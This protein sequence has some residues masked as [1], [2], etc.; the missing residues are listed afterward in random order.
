MIGKWGGV[1]IG[2][3][4]VLATALAAP[5]TA[6]AIDQSSIV[7][8]GTR[9]AKLR[10]ETHEFV[11]GLGAFSG[12]RQTARWVNDVC[13][14][15]IGV[16]PDIANKV[17]QQIRN[18]ATRAGARVAPEGCTP[19]FLIA[20]TTDASSF[21][22]KIMKR[23]PSA[24]G[25]VRTAGQRALESGRFPIRWWYN[26]A[27]AT[28]DGR[29]VLASGPAIN[30]LPV[31]GA[32]SVLTQY[33]TGRVSTGVV[34]GIESVS[35]IVDLN[36]AEGKLLKS[37]VDYAA[38]IGLSEIRLGASTAH[39]ILSMFEPAAGVRALTPLDEAYLHTL[40]EMA[41]DRTAKKQRQA[42]VDG[43]VRARSSQ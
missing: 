41:A 20:F 42:L 5:S 12:D 14:R 36:L 26:T 35:V 37:L 32:S 13:P 18:V 43:M 24:A 4:S 22:Q 3:L 30:N 9:T 16:D 8:E 19:N 7:V 31:T 6:R 17:Q 21:T 10:S 27:L 28:R 15:A 1:M 38:L 39:S 25:E 11:S 40:Y 23:D 2:M 33:E 34:R 29:P